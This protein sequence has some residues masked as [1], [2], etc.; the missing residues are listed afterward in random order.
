M[1]LLCT[2]EQAEAI[3]LIRPKVDF[4]LRD[5]DD[6]LGMDR[7]EPGAVNVELLEQIENYDPEQSE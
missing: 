6:N 2:D 7:Q 5:V 1:I 3:T 4:R